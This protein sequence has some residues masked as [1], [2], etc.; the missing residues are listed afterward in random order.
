MRFY[1]ILIVATILLAGI[2]VAKCH[3]KISSDL[4]PITSPVP[5]KSTSFSEYRE[6]LENIEDL[7]VFI[8]IDK[9]RRG[10]FGVSPDGMRIFQILELTETS[11]VTGMDWSPRTRKIALGLANRTRS[12]IF[13]IDLENYVLYNVTKDT[14]F[15]GSEPRWSPDGTRLA[16]VCGDY[17]PD[18][19]IIHSDGSGYVQL[20]SHPSRDINPSW[21][22]DGMSIVYQTSRGGLSD[23]YI[24][25]LQDQ[26][27]HDLTLGISQNAQPA[28]SPDG[29]MLL[30]Q[31]D[32]SGSMDIFLISLKDSSVI[33]I[34]NNEALDVDPRWSPDGKA[35][36]FRSDRDGEWDLFLM[37]LDE[38]SLMNLTMGWGPVFTYDWS[39]DGRYLVFSSG[40]SGN[41]KIYKVNIVNR[42]VTQITYGPSNDMAPLWISLKK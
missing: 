26:T 25:N 8:S 27:E 13:L 41:G 6:F 37:K 42:K 5:H 38:N 18:I 1:T 34:T 21:S 11:R 19:C 36:A 24:I 9:G 2:G 39:P 22:P 17:E 12:D 28:W 7:I 33:N 4:R 40:H 14:S 16:Y 29:K 32:R 31:S 23:I 20:T 3:K 15:G 30:F 10:I 35:I